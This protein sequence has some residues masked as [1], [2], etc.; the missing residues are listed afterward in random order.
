MW[1]AGQA[2]ISSLDK[3]LVPGLT[4]WEVS[5]S[6]MTFVLRSAESRCSCGVSPSHTAQPSASTVRQHQ[7]LLQ[8]LQTPGW[9]QTTNTANTTGKMME[10][11]PN[12]I[13]AIKTESPA[14]T[15]VDV[16][17]EAGG[18]SQELISQFVR[19][20]EEAE[21]PNKRKRSVP[22]KLSVEEE[23]EEEEELDM[24]EV[25]KVEYSDCDYH[26]DISEDP[27]SSEV[28]E[29]NIV[30]LRANNQRINCKQREDCPVC[31]DKANGLHYGIYSC[32]G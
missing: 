1:C 24:S 22:K 20:E 10:T 4:G 8:S 32:E 30:M 7:Q 15:M 13:A 27:V 5:W 21:N 12:V 2:V 11:F 9:Q 6:I 17:F 18:A 28:G 29:E 14:F 19:A 23:E 26:E 25:L 16:K 3:L 31:G